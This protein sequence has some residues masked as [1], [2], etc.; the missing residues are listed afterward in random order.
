MNRLQAIQA[1]RMFDDMG[2]YVFRRQ[3]LRACFNEE[4]EKT[5]AEGVARL[6]SDGLL[7]RAARG[8][9]VNE[10][11]KYGHGSTTERVATALR[12]ADLSSVSPESVL[13][14]YGISS[15]IHV[16]RITIM[17]TGREGQFRTPYGVIE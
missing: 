10:A 2:R 1:L 4:S 5:F 13:S 17:T 3:H 9:F 15:Q 7:V 11:A 6:V 14:E 12:P 16:E 8:V